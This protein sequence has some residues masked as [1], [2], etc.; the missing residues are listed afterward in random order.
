MALYLGRFK[1]PNVNW[2]NQDNNGEFQ[3]REKGN[4]GKQGNFD[5][6][7]GGF[8]EGGRNN[9]GGDR[10]NGGERG[11]GERNGG[12]QRREERGFEGK[13]GMSKPEPKAQGN[14]DY[15]Y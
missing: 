4:F 1:L 2:N 15:D 9:G 10:K 14:D 7:R 8:N 13:G 11:N 6:N 3:T 5:G 12:F